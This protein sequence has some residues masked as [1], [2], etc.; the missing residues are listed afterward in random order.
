MNYSEEHRSAVIRVLAALLEE[1]GSQRMFLRDFS[2]ALNTQRAVGRKIKIPELRRLLVDES[3][4][5]NMICKDIGLPPSDQLRLAWDELEGFGCFMINI[6]STALVAEAD[7]PDEC[8]TALDLCRSKL[9]A[10]FTRLLTIR[11]EILDELFALDFAPRLQNVAQALTPD[12][13]KAFP[14]AKQ[15]VVAALGKA[16]GDLLGKLLP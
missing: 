13:A 1:I 15:I 12:Q 14:L 10:M 8:A 7:L 3:Q 5:W 16:A 4:R 2:S 9:G 11:Q 6:L